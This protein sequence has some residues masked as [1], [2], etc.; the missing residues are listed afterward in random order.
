MSKFIPQHDLST[1]PITNSGALVYSRLGSAIQED[2]KGNLVVVHGSYQVD[3]KDI[4]KVLKFLDEQEATL[5]ATKNLDELTQN[6]RAE[7]HSIWAAVK[8]EED[9]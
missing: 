1:S 9:A 5:M 4:L 8:V 2:D 3:E 7:L 6:M